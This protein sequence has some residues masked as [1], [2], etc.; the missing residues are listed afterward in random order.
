MWWSRRWS[1]FSK[2]SNLSIL[3]LNLISG[4]QTCSNRQFGSICFHRCAIWIAN[5]RDTQVII[6][7]S[8]DPVDRYSC[9]YIYF[10]LFSQIK[11]NHSML[12]CSH[13]FRFA[14][15]FVCQSFFFSALLININSAI[16]KNKSI[17]L[18][19]SLASSIKRMECTTD[20]E[21][22]LCRRCVAI[23]VF[24]LHLFFFS[25]VLLKPS[26]SWIFVNM[27]WDLWWM[28]GFVIL[29]IR[30]ELPWDKV[31]RLFVSIVAFLRN[32]NKGKIRKRSYP[33]FYS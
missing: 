6:Q 24:R 2:Q 11:P 7:L 8:L 32:L 15:P 1:S 3:W 5:L 12:A 14:I 13:L 4:C 18:S 19:F 21:L 26:W 33:Y 20:K 23:T 10:N 16:R 30:F 9:E 22:K 25:D 29:F 28:A 31:C 17:I 27:H